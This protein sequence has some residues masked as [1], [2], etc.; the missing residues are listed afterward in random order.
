MEKYDNLS[1]VQH[2]LLKE[3]I[4]D[5]V[6]EVD[7]NAFFYV[8]EA[9]LRL[10]AKGS[11]PIEVLISSNGGQVSWGLHIYDALRLYAGVKT[12]TVSAAAMS[13]A[14][15][16]LQAC[17]LR[18]CYRHS[19]LRIHHIKR[20]DMSLDVFQDSKKLKEEIDGLRQR[21]E[22]IYKIFIARTGQEKEKIKKTCARD[23]D[24]TTEEALKFG[25]IDEII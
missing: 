2:A 11:P 14:T 21:Q 17:E 18:R 23:K 1:E 22:R 24:M 19:Y 4:I 5:I 3:N 16:I 9:L 6:G 20:N 12:G 25:L 13:M 7:M 10:R 15:V 8:R